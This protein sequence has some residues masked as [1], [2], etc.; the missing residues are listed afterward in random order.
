MRTQD[1][2]YGDTRLPSYFHRST[3]KVFDNFLYGLDKG[4]SIARV[5]LLR[6]KGVFIF[7]PQG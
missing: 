3:L 2:R 1:L 5:C 4:S 7:V 6:G